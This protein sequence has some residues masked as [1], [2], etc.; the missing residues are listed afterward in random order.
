MSYLMNTGASCHVV[1]NK[2]GLVNLQDQDDAVLI[3]DNLEMK[4]T[5]QGTIYLETEDKVLM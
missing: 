2:N 1:P 3:G 5:K 4:A